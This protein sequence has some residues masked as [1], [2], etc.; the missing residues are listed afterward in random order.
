MILDAEE[1]EARVNSPFNLINRLQN[2]VKRAEVISIPS[3]NSGLEQGTHQVTIPTYPNSFQSQ[4]SSGEPTIDNLVESVD[5]K[6]NKAT[7]I[8]GAKALMSES[9]SRLRTRLIEVDKPTDL[10]RIA[11]EMN[12]IV[13]NTEGNEKSKFNNIPIVIW[14]PEVHN[15]AHYETI[16][17]SD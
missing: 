17:V 13:N 11:V 5:D 15:E 10:A 9:I 7:A 4:P 2:A 3:L 1:I 6:I 14:K 8:S 12:K 16:I